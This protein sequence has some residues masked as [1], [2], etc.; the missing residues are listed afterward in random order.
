MYI[1]EVIVEGGVVLDCIILRSIYLFVFI[2][3]KCLLDH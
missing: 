1:T 2:C 3:F